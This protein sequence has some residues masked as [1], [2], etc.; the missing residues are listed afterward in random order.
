MIY[1]QK[2]LTAHPDIQD[3]GARRFTQSLTPARRP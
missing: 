3:I 2:C 1:T